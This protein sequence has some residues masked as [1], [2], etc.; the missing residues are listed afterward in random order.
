MLFVITMLF[1]FYTYYI[2]FAKM[3][4]MFNI[5]INICYVKYLNIFDLTSA[6]II[7]SYLLCCDNINQYNIMDINVDPKKPGWSTMNSILFKV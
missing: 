1:M 5:V 3:K 7:F 6:K 4:L 2:L